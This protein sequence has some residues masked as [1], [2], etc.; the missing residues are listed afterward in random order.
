[1]HVVLVVRNGSILLGGDIK[2]DDKLD[3]R[4]IEAAGK[5]VGCDDGV[6]RANSELVDHLVSLL[7]GHVT[8]N[9]NN[10]IPIFLERSEECLCEF[11]G[12][13]END[14]LSILREG[15][16]DLLDE[17]DLSLGWALVV[18]LL[19]IVSLYLFNVILDLIG[20]INHQGNLIRDLSF[21]GG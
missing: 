3:L 8:E 9:N 19:H 6:Y 16:V 11:L 18:E 12:V 1:M 15:V 7:L 13:H 2:I 4:H 20:L 5:Q 10:L 17:L 14:R 21:V